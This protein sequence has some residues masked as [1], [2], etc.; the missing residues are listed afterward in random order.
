M[1]REQN[2]LI[3]NGM[4]CAVTKALSCPEFDGFVAA[5]REFGLTKVF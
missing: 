3:E 4:I 5:G 2:D 1:K